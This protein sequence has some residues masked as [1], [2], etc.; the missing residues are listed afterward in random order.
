MLKPGM[1]APSLQSRAVH[2][3]LRYIIALRQKRINH[4]GKARKG[5]Q[6]QTSS[7]FNPR[8]GAWK[9][10]DLIQF[11][12]DHPWWFTLWLVLVL[13]TAGWVVEEWRKK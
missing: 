8:M 10:K 12:T 13:Q 4:L 1:Q 2:D 3:A 9:M 7:K 11:A 6:V 5:G